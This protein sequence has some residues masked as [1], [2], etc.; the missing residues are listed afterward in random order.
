M[1]SMLDELLERLADEDCVLVRIEATEGS[2]PREA[3]TWMA[4]WGMD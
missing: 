2:V 4:V 3:G 1:K